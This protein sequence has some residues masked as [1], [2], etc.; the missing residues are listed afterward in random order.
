[1]LVHIFVSLNTSL[2]PPALHGISSGGVSVS[3]GVF[4][5]LSVLKCVH[6]PTRG[7]KIERTKN[8]LCTGLLSVHSFC[9]S[10]PC[11][12]EL[13]CEEFLLLVCSFASS[14]T[15]CVE[16]RLFLEK[17]VLCFLQ[18]ELLGWIAHS[19]QISSPP[20]ESLLS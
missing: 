16:L 19:K 17:L 8:L 2:T 15:S 5:H 12:G 11:E 1:M 10:A 13:H 3:G 4:R 9:E 6:V 20:V 14:R 18:L 7:R